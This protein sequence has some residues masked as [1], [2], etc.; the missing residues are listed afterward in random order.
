ML[1]FISNILTFFKI[2]IKYNMENER[3]G[4]MGW[5]G[6]INSAF[7][8]WDRLKKWWGSNSHTKVPKECD[9]YYFEEY[10]KKVYIRK[11]GS[12]LVVSSFI[13]HVIDPNKLDNFV[14]SLDISDGK[15]D[16]AFKDFNEMKSVPI[17]KVFQEYGFWCIS[18]NDIVTDVEEYY[19]EIDR[20]REG[21]NK[22]LSFKMLID[23]A[24]LEK[25][26][27]Y[28]MA[29]AISV[30]GLFPIEDGRFDV[31][32]AD[33]DKYPD[34]NSFISASHFGDHLRFSLYF[35]KG[36]VFK[37]KPKGNAKR[38][39]TAPLKIEDISG[40]KCEFKDNIFYQKYHFE[41][42][43]PQDYESIYMK[44]NVKNPETK[45]GGIQMDKEAGC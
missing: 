43:H 34:F 40:K 28:S 25:N 13:L 41:I 3:N 42:E 10:N 19:D 15:R 17:E 8:L 6:D 5:V 36:I 29:Y 2:G 32:A 23:T 37:A 33:R 11:N 27:T 9:D 7:A 45:K 31:L 1:Q 18:E 21:D 4:Y 38:R 26:K 16:A 30:P 24:K 44:W 14:R 39:S 20:N 22:F 12:G 35:E